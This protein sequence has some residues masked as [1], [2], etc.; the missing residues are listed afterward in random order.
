MTWVTRIERGPLWFLGRL[1][2]PNTRR[3]SACE[4]RGE[5]HPEIM[6]AGRFKMCSRCGGW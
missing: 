6:D 1:L 5:H 3:V 4:N 2:I